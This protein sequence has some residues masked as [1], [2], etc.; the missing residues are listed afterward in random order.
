M[1][2]FNLDKL[3]WTPD[4]CTCLID[5][6]REETKLIGHKEFASDE[7]KLGEAGRAE[8]VRSAAG[9][10]IYRLPIFETIKVNRA[11]DVLFRKTHGMFEKAPPPGRRLRGT[12]GKPCPDH[13]DFVGVVQSQWGWCDGICRCVWQELWKGEGKELGY[14]GH[15]MCRVCPDHRLIQRDLI[16]ETVMEEARVRAAL[17]P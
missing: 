10:L 6:T 17:R 11:G 16:R 3:D 13:V 2:E 9:V 15:F 8:L 5:I 12:I 14:F 4:S 1:T 7:L